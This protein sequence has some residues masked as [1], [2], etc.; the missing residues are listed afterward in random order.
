MNAQEQTTLE[1]RD[2]ENNGLELPRAHAAFLD[3]SGPFSR[4]YPGQ[5]IRDTTLDADPIFLFRHGKRYHQPVA[6][7]QSAAR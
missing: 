1:S 6:G 2:Q 5:S 4:I 7:A 3:S